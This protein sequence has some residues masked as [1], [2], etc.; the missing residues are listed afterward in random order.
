MGIAEMCDRELVTRSL[1]PPNDSKRERL[2]GVLLD[3]TPRHQWLERAFSH[4]P[5]ILALHFRIY[6]VQKEFRG[7]GEELPVSRYKGQTIT[8][9]SPGRRDL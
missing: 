3:P 5:T 7:C 2:S 6:R 8:F 9:Y 1:L 4:D